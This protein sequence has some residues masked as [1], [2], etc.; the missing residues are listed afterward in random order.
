MSG[1]K[2]PVCGGFLAEPGSACGCGFPIKMPV[3]A[4]C[5]ALTGKP[6]RVS[7]KKSPS[8]P[9][10]PDNVNRCGVCGNNY[11]QEENCPQGHEAKTPFTL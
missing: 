6:V 1:N 11:G 7:E 5:N 3:K 9:K 8:P 10:N 2:C 4:G